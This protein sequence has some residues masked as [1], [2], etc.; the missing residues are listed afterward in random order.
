MARREDRRKAIE[1]RRRGKTY[2]E[3]RQKLDVPK[4]TLSGW[5]SGYHLSEGELVKL[6]TNI[7]R[8]RY[9]GIE[10]TRI[11]KAKK[12]Q[13]RLQKTYKQEERRL[14][15]LTKREFYLCG[16]FLYWGEGVKGLRTGVSLNNTDPKVIKFYYLWMT[17]TLGIPKEKVKVAVHL[18]EDMDV[19]ESLDYWS[20]LLGISRKQFIKPY[21]K[22][23]NRKEVDHKGFGRGTCGLYVYDQ[24]LKERIMLGIEAI[25]DY[26]YKKRG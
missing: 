16:L 2:S 17:R 9:L 26:F 22:K 3:I 23:S 4:S 25:S 15:P 12:R 21:I 1:L 18:Y 19:E 14:L 5:L 13:K 6:K 24:K 8:R 20:R 7:K 10:K 11:T